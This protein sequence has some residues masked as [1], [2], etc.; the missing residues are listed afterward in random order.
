MRCLF[1]PLLIFT[2]ILFGKPEPEAW[3]EV[4]DSNC[5]VSKTYRLHV[6][7]IYGLGGKM[8]G[9]SQKSRQPSRLRAPLRHPQPKHFMG[10]GSQVTNCQN[11]AQVTLRTH[12]ETEQTEKPEFRGRA[13]QHAPQM[14]RLPLK[15]NRLPPLNLPDFYKWSSKLSGREF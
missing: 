6:A 2:P 10:W 4:S 1:S 7:A 12:E 14:A 11:R 8:M 15:S 9:P 5:C 3:G 13:A